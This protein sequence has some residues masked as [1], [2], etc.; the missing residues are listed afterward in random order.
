MTIKQRKVLIRLLQQYLALMEKHDVESV[1]PNWEGFFSRKKLLAM[2]EFLY[3][4]DDLQKYHLKN[5]ENDELLKFIHSDYQLIRYIIHTLQQD[6]VATPN[7]SGKEINEFFTRI[8]MENHYLMYKPPFQWDE[9]DRSNY[10]SLLF[11]HGKTKRVF[12]IF[13]A[14]VDEED[15][16]AVTTQPSYFFDSKEE[17]E[18]ELEKILLEKRFNREELKIMSLWQIQ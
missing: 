12:A 16:Y 18:A 13:T 15:K 10:Y 5:M 8:G 2:I 3:D 1:N 11:K 17:A 9:Y 6:I 7:I 14:D 4:D